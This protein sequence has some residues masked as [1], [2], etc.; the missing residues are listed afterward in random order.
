MGDTLY[1]ILSDLSGVAL[2]AVLDQWDRVEQRFG[3]RRV[4]AS[5]LPH[6]TYACGQDARLAELQERLAAAAAQ[7]EP[8][9][10]S[11]NG[12]GVFEGPSPV[13][14]LRVEATPALERVHS[15]VASAVRA[16]GMDLIPHYHAGHWTPHV[17]LAVGDLGPA[18]LEPV[19]A[20]LG[21]FPTVF[22]AELSSLTLLEVTLPEYPRIVTLP[23][24]CHL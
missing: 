15:L 13:V 22:Q 10:V 24:R 4:R 8:F 19:L 3:L 1:A 11:L 2:E 5:T 20:E 23:F 14:F 21:R 6:I 18:Q 9:T 16:A 17:T 7:I 12:I